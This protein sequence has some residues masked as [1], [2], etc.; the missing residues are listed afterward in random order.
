MCICYL[1][2]CV[3]ATVS[4]FLLQLYIFLFSFFIV[5]SQCEHTVK[6]N[7]EKRLHNLFCKYVDMIIYCIC[8]Y[9]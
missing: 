8:I 1:S 2:L 9:V 6:C 5:I 4:M 3:I 7:V